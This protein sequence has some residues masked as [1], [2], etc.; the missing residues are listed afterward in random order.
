MFHYSTDTFTGGFVRV[1]KGVRFQTWWW[2][3]LRY[4]T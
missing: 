1:C 3:C 4:S 2:T